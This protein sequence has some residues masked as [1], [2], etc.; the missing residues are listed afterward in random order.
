[1]SIAPSS[2]L[3]VGQTLAIMKVSF[4][5]VLIPRVQLHTIDDGRCAT[6]LLDALPLTLEIR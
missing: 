2:R 1:M 6:L 5:G 4:T 3:P